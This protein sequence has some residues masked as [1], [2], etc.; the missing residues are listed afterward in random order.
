MNNPT[1][2]SNT[3]GQLIDQTTVD[4]L[5]EAQAR[6]GNFEQRG[7][8]VI[9][10]AGTLVT[11]LLAL[12]AA[13]RATVKDQGLPRPA[14]GPVTVA[15]TFL[16]LA[17]LL[18]LFI[19]LP[20]RTKDA[21]LGELEKRA[22]KL[23]WEVPLSPESGKEDRKETADNRRVYWASQ[24]GPDDLARWRYL[25]INKLNRRNKVTAWLLWMAVVLEMLALVVLAWAVMTLLHL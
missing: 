11:L 4:L 6:K 5:S 9:S 23:K 15:L 21:R 10:S 22:A 20:R 2:P 19:N 17:A 24:V 8:A 3:V 16:I 18:A 1:T 14:H 25:S 7:L 12:T 13:L